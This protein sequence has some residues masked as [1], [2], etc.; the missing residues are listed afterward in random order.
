MP[1]L[2]L[3]GGGYEQTFL[4]E[5]YTVTLFCKPFAMPPSLLLLLRMHH[6]FP[7][8]L[9]ILRINSSRLLPLRTVIDILGSSRRRRY[10]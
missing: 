1:D 3:F 4:D 6:L 8:V 7:A 2:A 10:R 5:R 9:S